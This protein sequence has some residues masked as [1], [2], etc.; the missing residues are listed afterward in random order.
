MSMLRPE[1]DTVAASQ[2]V[3]LAA[4]GLSPHASKRQTMGSGA[5]PLDMGATSLSPRMS[6][7]RNSAEVRHAA[8]HVTTM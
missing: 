7:P 6:R 3:K 4:Q 8:G 2:D 1:P 5:Q